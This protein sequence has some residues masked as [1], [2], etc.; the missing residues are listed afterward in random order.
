MT[1]LCPKYPDARTPIAGKL[2][3]AVK[4]VRIPPEIPRNP[5]TV[6][7]IRSHDVE[8]TESVSSLPRQSW[9][10]KHCIA[11]NADR[12]AASP[13]AWPHPRIESRRR[14]KLQ[15]K[16]RILTPHHPHLQTRAFHYQTG[17]L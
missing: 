4:R 14:R 15:L 3:R 1:E 8:E 7:L 2:R 16:Q 5:G 12:P 6:Y 13:G 11:G 9:S 17:G 10:D